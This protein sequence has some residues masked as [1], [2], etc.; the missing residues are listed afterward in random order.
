MYDIELGNEHLMRCEIKV[1]YC[2]AYIAS[3]ILGASRVGCRL[4]SVCIQ[5][6]FL[7]MHHNLLQIVEQIGLD[8]SQAGSIQ[9]PC[10]TILVLIC[11]FLTQKFNGSE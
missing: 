2:S 5:G 9:N 7:L 10:Q 4:Q 6:C 8:L 11:V 3:V 1:Y